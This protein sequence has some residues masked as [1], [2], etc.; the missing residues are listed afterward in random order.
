MGITIFSV[1]FKLK[2]AFLS[3][4]HNSLK[5]LATAVGNVFILIETALSY[6]WI[7]IMHCR[8]DANK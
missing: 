3:L 1:Q 5:P 8:A 6:V 7:K 2:K 4:S